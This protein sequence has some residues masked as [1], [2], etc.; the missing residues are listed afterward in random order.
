[1]PRL[2]RAALIMHLQRKAIELGVSHRILMSEMRDH[3]E[4]RHGRDE[5][6]SL[7]LEEMDSLDWSEIAERAHNNS[8]KRRNRDGNGNPT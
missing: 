2:S 4:R 8:L 6:S 1:M 7:S 3:F 5:Y